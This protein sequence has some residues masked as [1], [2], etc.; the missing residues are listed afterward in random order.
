MS[1]SPMHL[2]FA[3]ETRQAFQQLRLCPRALQQQRRLGE[4][5]RHRLCSLG[6]RSGAFRS[7]WVVTG[8]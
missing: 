6:C 4:P 2:I 8:V 1:I 5:P 7:E 3:T